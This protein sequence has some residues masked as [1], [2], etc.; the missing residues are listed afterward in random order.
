MAAEVHA[1]E[2]AAEHHVEDGDIVGKCGSERVEG[3]L[4]A[5]GDVHRDAG[6]RQPSGQ[7]CGN[8]GFVLDDQYAHAGI[9]EGGHRLQRL[10]E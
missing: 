6:F 10:R 4:A 2:V 5:Q 1:V 7:A 8:L 3:L 9:V